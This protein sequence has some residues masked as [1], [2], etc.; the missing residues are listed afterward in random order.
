MCN[1]SNLTLRFNSQVSTAPDPPTEQ[2][3]QAP[4]TTHPTTRAP[5]SHP[6]TYPTLPPRVCPSIKQL[7][8]RLTSAQIKRSNHACVRLQ[9]N[10]DTLC[11]D[12]ARSG[13][14]CTTICIARMESQS[15][16]CG[17]MKRCPVLWRYAVVINSSS[18]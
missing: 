8:N 5:T 6:T 4:P 13:K 9:H 12:L 2:P 11:A 15:E 1:L 10:A 17:L 14:L 3:T 18:W 16:Q 7:S